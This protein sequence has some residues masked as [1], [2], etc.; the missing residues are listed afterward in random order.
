MKLAT[1]EAELAVAS[2]ITL[3]AILAAYAAS[4]IRLSRLEATAFILCS[5]SVR[6]SSYSSPASAV[7]AAFSSSVED[8]PNLKQSEM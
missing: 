3:L 5:G 1:L 2:F 7:A 6:I 8:P 4:S